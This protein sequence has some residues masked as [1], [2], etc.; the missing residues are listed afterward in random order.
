MVSVPVHSCI[1]PSMLPCCH[2]II[3]YCRTCI[4]RPGKSYKFHNLP[5]TVFTKTCLSSLSWKKPQNLLITL[6]MFHCRSI[7]WIPQYIRQIS[8]NA[9]L[10]NRNV[11]ISVHM[12]TFLLQSGALW[13]MGLVH[14]GICEMDLFWYQTAT[15]LNKVRTVCI[16]LGM[17]V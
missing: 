4:M 14:C 8:H 9:P 3:W 7:S 16:I 1:Y 6:Y 11:H 17:Y 5:V 2:G 13:D 12:C 10:C 15:N